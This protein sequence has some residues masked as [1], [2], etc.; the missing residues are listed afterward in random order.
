MV[1]LPDLFIP[2]RCCK[3]KKSPQINTDYLTA[4]TLQ[5]AGAA[6]RMRKARN[7]F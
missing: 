6:Q 4:R 1:G 7:V 5:P 2:Q 3:Q